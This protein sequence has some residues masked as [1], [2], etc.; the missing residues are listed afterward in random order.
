MSNMFVERI[1]EIENDIMIKKGLLF[2]CDP[3]DR[4]HKK[5]IMN[6]IISLENMLAFNMKLIYGDINPHKLHD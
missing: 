2:E 3:E 5:I 1:E 4:I 6:Q